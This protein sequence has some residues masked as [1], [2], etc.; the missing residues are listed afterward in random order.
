MLY[1]SDAD[2]DG[3]FECGTTAMPTR[4]VSVLTEWS[5]STRRL[6]SPRVVIGRG[7]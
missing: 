6:A 4:C 5:G 2:P 3:D 1:C 7:R